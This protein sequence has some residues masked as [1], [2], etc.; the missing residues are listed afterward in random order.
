MKR[1][2]RRALAPRAALA[3]IALCALAL[4]GVLFLACTDGTTPD[5]SDAA[6]PCGPLL[7][8]DATPDAVDSSTIVPDGSSSTGDSSVVDANDGALDASDEG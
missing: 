8:S 6:T 4:Q 5:C 3:A 2:L 1:P 7:A